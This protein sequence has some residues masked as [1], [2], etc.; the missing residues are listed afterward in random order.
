[1]SSSEQYSGGK[2]SITKLRKFE[3]NDEYKIIDT[4][5]GI[6]ERWRPTLNFEKS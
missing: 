2:R 6:E 5:E 3:G 4:S 1:M